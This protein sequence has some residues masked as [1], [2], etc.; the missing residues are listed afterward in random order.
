MA[1][2]DITASAMALV[3]P[4]ADQGYTV[5]HRGECLLF[6]RPKGGLPAGPPSCRYV[7]I[8][9]II[10]QGTVKAA[11]RYVEACFG[12]GVRNGTAGG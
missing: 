12:K 10:D 6:Y 8:A 1:K 11:C 4:L 7:S 9:G 3:Q 5:I 2:K